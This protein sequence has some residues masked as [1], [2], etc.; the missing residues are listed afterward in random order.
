[1]KQFRN[2][3]AAGNEQ[4][5]VGFLGISAVFACTGFFGLLPGVNAANYHHNHNF[6]NE[7]QEF[8]NKMGKID[9]T[10]TALYA[11]IFVV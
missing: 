7:R 6:T 1:M 4:R 3:Q 9:S 8:Q 5:F 2:L 10:E 11:G